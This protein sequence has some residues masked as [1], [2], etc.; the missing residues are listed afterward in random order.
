MNRQLETNH[1]HSI[2]IIE[3]APSFSKYIESCIKPLD[4]FNLFTATAFDE[5][6][7]IILAENPEIIIY[8]L[9]LISDD[10]IQFLDDV[11]QQNPGIPFKIGLAAMNDDSIIQRAYRMGSDYFLSKSFT[12]HELIGI[13]DNIV[14]QI[15]Y[16]QRIFEQEKHYR[17]LFQLAA[18]PILLVSTNDFSILS[19]NEAAKRLYGFESEAEESYFLDDI[20]PDF[21]QLENLMQGK[22]KSIGGA[23]HQTIENRKIPVIVNIS[24]L[25]NQGEEV[26]LMSVKDIR[27]LLTEVGK[28]VNFYTHGV[29]KNENMVSIETKAFLLGEENERRRIQREIHDHVGQLLVSLKLQLEDNLTKAKD[30][31]LKSDLVQTRNDLIQ[32]IKTLRSI[33]TKIDEELLPKNDLDIALKELFL[34]TA[35]KHRF[36]IIKEGDYRFSSL[37]LLFQAH[38]FRIIEE[39]LTNS[40]KYS[41]EQKYSLHIETLQNQQLALTLTSYGMNH[42]SSTIKLS[43]GL[44]FM[45]HRASMIGGRIEFYS[46]VENQ[47]IIKLTFPIPKINL[48]TAET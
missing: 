45:Q 19:Y 26:A 20:V 10:D 21:A 25:E 35:D 43:G 30:E 12:R 38:V 32:A 8:D 17:S 23:N 5:A 4:R 39:S 42:Q 14:R 33:T 7:S 15:A 41:T 46:G 28:D 48:Q 44:R 18:D 27:P 3:E 34:R 47:F 37:P 6:R 9:F 31:S 16:R 24:Y 36:E 22:V 13:L 11:Q 1:P 40:L 29:D 2:L